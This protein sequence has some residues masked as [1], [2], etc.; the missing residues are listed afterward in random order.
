MQAV[1]EHVGG[2]EAERLHQGHSADGDVDFAVRVDELEFLLRWHFL[3]RAEVML[4]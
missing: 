1:D 4:G 2:H 3:H